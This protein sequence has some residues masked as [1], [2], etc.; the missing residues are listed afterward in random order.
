LYVLDPDCSL[1][2]ITDELSWVAIGSARAIAETFLAFLRH[3]LW[4]DG[5]PST[6]HAELAAYWT[7]R[8]A[9]DYCPAGLSRPIQLTL[10]NRDEGGSFEIVERGER[11][12]AVIDQTIEAS[13][14]AIRRS[15]GSQ[16]GKPSASGGP[17][18]TTTPPPVPDKP[19]R[20]RV[21]EVRLR[22]ESP[23]QRKRNWK[24]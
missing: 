23:E 2:E 8:H 11:E 19:P 15:F 7:V 1:T 22:I 24:W 5:L 18:P 4:H 10:V 12:L 20:K 9:L 17:P 3:V 6:A 14:E 21:P 13:V 16:R